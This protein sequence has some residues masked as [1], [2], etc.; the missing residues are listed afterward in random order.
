VSLPVRR[1]AT[2]RGRPTVARASAGLSASRI[3]AAVTLLASAGALYGVSVSDAFALEPAHV[4]VEGARYAGEAAVREALGLER[5]STNVFR[6]RTGDLAERLRAIPAVAEATVTVA[7]PDR[8]V[9]RLAERTPILVW[10]RGEARFLVDVEGVLFARQKA[11][12]TA[13]LPV[14]EDRRTSRAAKAIDVGARLGAIDLAVVRR[15]GAL[16]PSQVGSNA[17]AFAVSRTDQEGWVVEAGEGRWRAVFGF[18]TPTLRTPELLPR[19]VQCL[20]ELLVGREE[21]LR[22]VYLSPVGE[23]CGTYVE[24]TP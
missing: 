3:L 22:V 2:G 7:L 4:H 9:V 24:E 14:I 1:A 17:P 8:L 18:Y 13:G 6:L 23:R 5:G 11:A 21:R 15:L 19:Q 10:R 20:G 12:D 16:E